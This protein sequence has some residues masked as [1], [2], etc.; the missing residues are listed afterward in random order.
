MKSSSSQ[1]LRNFILLGS[2]SSKLNK[3]HLLKIQKGHLNKVAIVKTKRKQIEIVW[4]LHQI[5]EKAAA[6]EEKK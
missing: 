6:S 3:S 2:L 4:H 1:N 5:T